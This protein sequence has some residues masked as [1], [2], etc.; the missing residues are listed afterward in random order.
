MG[1]R[2]M[3]RAFPSV[4]DFFPEIRGDLSRV[5]WAHAVDSRRELGQALSGKQV[6]F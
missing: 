6:N 3:K 4:A 1:L 2:R 5:K